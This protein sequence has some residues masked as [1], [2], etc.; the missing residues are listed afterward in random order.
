MKTRIENA[1]QE[2]EN[3]QAY[4]DSH[5]STPATDDYYVAMSSIGCALYELKEGAPLEVQN[6]IKKKSLLDFIGE[7]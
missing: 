6:S 7:Y 2:L 4:L 1:I 3:I 5:K